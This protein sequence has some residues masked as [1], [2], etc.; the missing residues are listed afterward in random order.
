MRRWLL[1]AL[2]LALPG[3]GRLKDCSKWPF[4]AAREYWI[5]LRHTGGYGTLETRKDYICIFVQGEEERYFYRVD[6]KVL[7]RAAQEET[8]R[9]IVQNEIGRLKR[10]LA[11]RAASAPRLGSPRMQELEDYTGLFFYYPE[12]WVRWWEENHERLRIAP[13]GRHL[14]VG[15]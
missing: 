14:I 1:L 3:C 5:M 11:R 15:K 2:C 12:Q 8:Y 10:W 6:R 7:T 4:M 13:D 9:L